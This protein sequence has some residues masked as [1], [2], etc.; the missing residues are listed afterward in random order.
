MLF[1]SLPRQRDVMP[2]RSPGCA[3]VLRGAR[4]HVT[5]FSYMTL[6]DKS[7]VKHNM[8]KCETYLTLFNTRCATHRVRKQNAQCTVPS[9]EKVFSFQRVLECVVINI[10]HIIIHVNCVCFYHGTACSSVTFEYCNVRCAEQLYISWTTVHI[11]NI[12]TYPEQMYVSWTTVR[13]LKN[14][15]YPEKLYVSWTTVHILNNCTYPEHTIKPIFLW[16]LTSPKFQYTGVLIS[17]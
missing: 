8:L 15:T 7:A 17:P 16:V 13:I 12:C 3:D 2:Y 5:D 9:A 4:A 11:L 10:R 14:C 6:M 1:W